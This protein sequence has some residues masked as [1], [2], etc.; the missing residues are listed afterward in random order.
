MTREVDP[1][2]AAAESQLERIDDERLVDD[3]VQASSELG[4]VVADVDGYSLRLDE[5]PA[6][7]DEPDGLPAAAVAEADAIDTIA[8][9]FNARDLD[10]LMELLAPDAEVP[11]LLGYERD[12]VADALEDLWN[13]RPTCCVTRG[14]VDERPLGVL[15]DHDG[16]RWWMLATVHVADVDDGVVGV[17]EVSDDAALLDSIQ[18]DPP[19][20]DEL[21]EGS[22]W[23]EW[24][25][26]EDST[27]PRL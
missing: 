17:I 4:A 11:G 15:W 16:Q 7:V 26:G 21:Q 24:D 6:D 27:P 20:P 25:E 3:H 2:Q 5:P 8:E 9:L 19:D 1:H 23:E 12:N 22:R 13:R 10:G 14:A 18:A